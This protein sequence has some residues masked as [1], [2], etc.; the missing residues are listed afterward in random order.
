MGDFPTRAELQKIGRD[1][2]L[3][4]NSKLT[5]ETIDR[6]GSDANVVAA[7]MSAVGDECIGQL[8]RVCAALTLGVA[9]GRALD[10]LVF[11][12]YGLLRKPA[13]PGR[14]SIRFTTTVPA[15][16]GFAIPAGTK[17]STS[18][19]IQFLTVVGASYPVGS[20]GPVTV[21]VRSAAAG[22]NQAAAAGTI[23]NIVSSIVGAP[24]DLA[25]TNPLAT[26]GAADEETD[27]RYRDRA[28]AYFPTVRR[29]TVAAVELQ[30]KSVPG[31]INA[32]CFED[33][34]M[35]GRPAKRAQLVITDQYT[36][37]L[38]NLADVPPTYQ[39][40]SQV[41]ARTVFA[42]LYD[43][44]P[45]GIYIDVIV[46][47]LI[48]Q[49]VVLA[50]SFQ[51]GY[52]VDSVAYAARVAVVNYINS[53]DPGAKLLREN[54]VDALRYVRG[55]IVSGDEILSPA[56]DVVPTRL[57]VLRTTLGLVRASTIQP[58]AAL[59]GTS[60]PDAI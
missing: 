42:A 28:R 57:E 47:Q 25:A 33:L 2:M 54:L 8:A 44:R 4:L 20:V 7:A 1:Y 34:D 24:A 13:A 58:D 49:P 60:N 23:T 14:T 10:K 21:E 51:A 32:R 6:D 9:K 26:S 16:G 39:T 46:G 15:A 53:L 56:G 22:V 29:G 11:D 5:R 59:A 31:V 18:D 17:L 19:G 27:D 12:R 45:D 36:D 43:T 37:Q 35:W 38:A 52:N 30:A 48:L 40:Q 50:L 41:L 3:M 55:L